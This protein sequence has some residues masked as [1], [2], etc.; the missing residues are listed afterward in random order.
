MTHPEIRQLLAPDPRRKILLLVL[1]GLGG[2][3]DPA[4][5]RTELESAK[6][7]N[8][9]RLAREASGGRMQTIDHGVTPG[10]GPAHL[11][12]F[13]YHPYEV[14]IGRGV[15]EALGSGFELAPGDLAAR[16]NYATLDAEG[17][18]R[19]RRAGRPTDQENRRLCDKLQSGIR[20]LAGGV[21]VF[22]LPGKEHRFTVVFRQKSAS[23]SVA[24]ELDPH[25]DDTD[26]QREGEL[27]VDVRPGRPQA[28]RSAAVVQ[29]FLDA[30]RQ[31]LRDEKAASGVLL[32]GFSGP[33]ELTSFNECY[34][35]RAGAIAAYP[36]YRGVAR[37]VGMEVLGEPASFEEELELLESRYEDYDFF[38]IHFKATD[39]A[40]HSGDFAAKV[41][42]LET[43][44]SNIPRLEALNPEVFVVTGDHSTPCVHKEHSWHPVPTIIRS[45]LSLPQPDAKFTE[46]SLMHGDLGTFPAVQ[47]MPLALAHASRLKKFGA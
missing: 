13:G 9:D 7:P 23:G 4:T 33:I 29:E 36:M 16:A 43:V 12:L 8:L 42:E 34:G 26:P 31:I 37:L 24:G 27:P 18:V 22:L 39:S 19:D 41:R 30:A 46:R 20:D 32:R 2:L 14:E 10:S 44:D 3:P 28:N 25:L 5:G 45:P 1:D 40:G 35:V 38:F 17:V 11:A 6:I 21:E 15:L 47:L